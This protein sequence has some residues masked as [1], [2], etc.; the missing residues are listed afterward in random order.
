M[1]AGLGCLLFLLVGSDSEGQQGKGTRWGGGGGGSCSW[2]NIADLTQISHQKSDKHAL[3][4]LGLCRGSAV[5]NSLHEIVICLLLFGYI[6][7]KKLHVATWGGDTYTHTH[8]YDSEFLDQGGCA[9][10]NLMFLLCETRQAGPWSVC[11][12]GGPT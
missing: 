4:R 5:A 3:F 7:W 6:K 1:Q 9:E 12:I 2:T 8:T 10:P 11:R